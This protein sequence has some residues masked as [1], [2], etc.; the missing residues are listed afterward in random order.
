MG[1]EYMEKLEQLKFNLREKQVP[2]FDEEELKLLLQKN[3]D[4]VNK[5]SYEG[6]ILKAEVTGLNVS[7]LTTKD[8][9]GY[10]KMLASHFVETNSGVLAG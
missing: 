5:A 4:D 9:S 7:G 6:L 10:F 3:N 8:S 2:Y 1:G